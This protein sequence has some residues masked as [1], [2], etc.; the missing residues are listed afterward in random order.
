MAQCM[1]CN[2]AGW[3]SAPAN[4]VLAKPVLFGTVSSCYLCNGT[5]LTAISIW[6]SG[7]D[8]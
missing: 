3:H 8:V 4:P 2:G 6:G 5:G 1:S 7:C